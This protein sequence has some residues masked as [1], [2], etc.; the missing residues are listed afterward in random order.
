MAC[1]STPLLP[2]EAHAM[3]TDVFDPVIGPDEFIDCHVVILSNG[4][5]SDLRF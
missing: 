5:A 1:R 4:V 3:P 2:L